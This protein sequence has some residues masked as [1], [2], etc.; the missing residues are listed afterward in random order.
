M[1]KNSFIN[2][3]SETIYQNILYRNM[4]VAECDDQTISPFKDRPENKS[5]YC[6]VQMA[7]GVEQKW[8]EF[9][10]NLK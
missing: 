4:D 9:I 2:I 10:N 8:K 6:K 3:D 7:E 1:D 5:F